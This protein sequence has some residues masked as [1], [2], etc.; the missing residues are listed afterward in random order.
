MD[1]ISRFYC[2]NEGY[3]QQLNIQSFLRSSQYCVYFFTFYLITLENMQINR[4]PSIRNI[5]I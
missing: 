5:Q 3:L 1:K 4:Y 2:L